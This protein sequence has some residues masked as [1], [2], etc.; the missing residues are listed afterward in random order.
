MP[1][2]R[3]F[4][5]EWL[6]Y[7]AV[8]LTLAAG[9]LFGLPALVRPHWDDLVVA[10]GGGNHAYAR[11]IA[12]THMVVLLLGNA[13]FLAIYADFGGIGRL[14]RRWKISHKAWPWQQGA[15]QRAD[16]FKL[17]RLAIG[18]TLANNL[19]LAF[20]AAYLNYG[21]AL[22][23]GYKDDAASLPSP[24][25]VAWQTL[26]FIAIEDTLFYHVH[27]GLHSW[28]WLYKRVHK[29]H[30]RY[31]YSVSIAAEFAHPLEFLLGNAIPFTLGPLLLGAH[32][33]TMLAWVVFRIGETVDGHSGFDFPFSPF[34]LLPFAGSATGHDL[35]HSKNTGNYE[36]FL[37]FWER[38]Y[39]TEIPEPREGSSDEPGELAQKA[40]PPAS[41]TTAGKRAG[42][43]AVDAAAAVGGTGGTGDAEPPSS[44]TRRRAR[45]EQ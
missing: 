23:Y 3:A 16:F 25:T 4:S 10:L 34:R 45:K 32:L 26:A 37:C 31:Y 7:K 9:W 17:V 20:P 19:L 36:S 29:L 5:A 42:S 38:L 24:F 6:A 22:K 30:H 43:G 18:L 27:R 13:C 11:G 8:A 40:S 41:G 14:C 33:Y 12:L 1:S 44:G 21:T 39:G 28:P 35:H 15:E 2:P